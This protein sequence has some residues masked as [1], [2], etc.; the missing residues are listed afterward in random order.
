MIDIYDSSVK[1]AEEHEYLY[2]YT[3]DESL[4][5]I[6]KNKSLLLNR[7]DK[8]NDPDE[9]RRIISLWNKKVFAACFTHTLDNE[10]YMKENYG[11]NRI[12][13]ATK[14]LL[15]KQV[16]SDS[17]CKNAMTFIERAD[18]NYKN[19]ED[20]SDW[21]WFDYSV[22]DV[23]YVESLDDYTDGITEKNAGLIKLKEGIDTNGR[24]RRWMNEEET[25][26]RVAVKPFALEFRSNGKGGF[27]YIKPSF[28]RVFIDIR[29]AFIEVTKL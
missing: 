6:L 7:L 4:K 10:K 26:V 20:V 14:E 3:T 16:Y 25:R 21:G 8:V 11:T 12:K 27:Y 1:L 2:H 17:E 9:N 29:S 5:Y 15:K 24:P 13:L 19:Y 23:C 22:G 28:E 18:V